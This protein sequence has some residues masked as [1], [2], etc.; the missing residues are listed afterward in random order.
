MAGRG[1][2]WDWLTAISGLTLIV[3]QFLSW[4]FTNEEYYKAVQKLGLTG[5][6]LF[7]VGIFA[8]LAPL[9]NT[10]RQTPGRASSYNM[11]LVVMGLLSTAFIIFRLNE[12]PELD[13]L[14]TPVQI[15]PGAYVGLC[16]AIGIVVFSALAIATRKA[17]RGAGAAG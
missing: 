1:T 4:Y 7:I 16:A 17:R 11:I 12:T 5:K 2:I 15:E 14:D 8:L 9:V 10:L 6:L 3:S 13:T